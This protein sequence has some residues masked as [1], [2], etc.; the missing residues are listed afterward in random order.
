MVK[1]NLCNKEQRKKQTNQPGTCMSHMDWLHCYFEGDHLHSHQPSNC[2][3]QL[4]VPAA[5]WCGSTI[6]NGPCHRPKHT[7][8]YSVSKRDA[9]GDTTV[10]LRFCVCVCVCLYVRMEI[11]WLSMLGIH[12]SADFGHCVLSEKKTAIRTCKLSTQKLLDFSFWIWKFR[13]NCGNTKVIVEEWKKQITLEKPCVSIWSGETF[14]KLFIIIRDQRSPWPQRNHESARHS[15]HPCQKITRS[16][17]QPVLCRLG[18]KHFVL[19]WLS[20]EKSSTNSSPVLCASCPWPCKSVILT[21]DE[22]QQTVDGL[23]DR[24]MTRESDLQVFFPGSSPDSRETN[25]HRVGLL[26]RMNEV[27]RASLIFYLR[28]ECWYH[29]GSNFVNHIIS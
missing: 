29:T 9:P 23:P 1:S 14:I 27:Y 2:T 21:S 15:F 22:F 7:C 13:G 24:V 16:E 6:P 8:Q 12:H 4:H 25:M 19:Y 10:F 5:M 18:L 20:V 3:H 26:T 28:V 17:Y 11:L